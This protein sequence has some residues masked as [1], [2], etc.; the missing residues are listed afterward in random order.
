MRVD[1]KPVKVCVWKNEKSGLKHP[2]IVSLV[3]V[4]GDLTKILWP[5]YKV[6]RFVYVESYDE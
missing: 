5:I 1:E 2:H 3:N 4:E 6:Q